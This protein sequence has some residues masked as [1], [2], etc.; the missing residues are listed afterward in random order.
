MFKNQ[1][2]VIKNEFYIFF[3][4]CTFFKYGFWTY[5]R[6]V[7]LELVINLISCINHN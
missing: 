6:A 3:L 2:K 7:D 1:E 4:F 5:A